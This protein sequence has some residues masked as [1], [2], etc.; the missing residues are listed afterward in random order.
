[1]RREPRIACAVNW[2][3]CPSR[4]SPANAA[5]PPALAARPPARPI[6]QATAPK[7][8]R[9]QFAIGEE[10]HEKLRRLQTLLRREIPD[11]DPAAIF[12]RALGLLLERVERTKL[13]AR[14]RPCSV[15]RPGT[16][17]T[18]ER[19]TT[20]LP[21]GTSSRRPASE[22]KQA[23]W[24][25]D[26][27]QCTFVSKSGRRCPEL[28]FLEYHHIWPYAR[29]GPAT[30]E[31]MCLLCRRHNVHEAEVEFGPRKVVRTEQP[32]ES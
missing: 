31:N 24:R 29:Q 9:V 22:V 21:A 19:I 30:V 14:R 8:Y 4:Y 15:I 6:V 7:R 1:M 18:D 5:C 12:D 17:A 2:V 32:A 28:T 13:G 11:G 26:G 25:R 10:T 23:V 16:D 27:G 3:P 20:A